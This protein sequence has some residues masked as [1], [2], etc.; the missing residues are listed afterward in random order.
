VL[1]I[2]QADLIIAFIEDIMEM[3][4]TVLKNAN[5]YETLQNIMKFEALDLSNFLDV[6][7]RDCVLQTYLPAGVSYKGIDLYPLD[8]IDGVDR[9]DL[10]KGLPYKDNSYD[11]V[12]ALDV[13]EHCD[14]IFFAFQ[15]LYR[16]SS[17]Y[18]VINLPNELHVCH[19]IKFLFGRTPG[20]FKL[21]P[22]GYGDRHRWFFT[23]DNCAEFVKHVNKNFPVTV[24]IY[25]LPKNPRSLFPRIILSP[26]RN[27]KSLGAWSYLLLIEK[28]IG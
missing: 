12:A 4:L 8:G 21:N 22:D 7:C 11:M 6:G 28:N 15:E 20:N 24:R 2:P 9:G 16:T 26:F 23:W 5:R 27:S 1:Y 18:I 10:E 3:E 13:L 17:K 19:R 25:S 14:D